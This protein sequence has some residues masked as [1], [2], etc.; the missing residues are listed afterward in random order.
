M[1]KKKNDDSKND[2]S[3]GFSP[4]KNLSYF[5]FVSLASGLK[6]MLKPFLREHEAYAFGMQ[7]FFYYQIRANFV[8][9]QTARMETLAI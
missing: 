6:K 2:T 7:S 9:C 1:G 5:F 8:Q 3:L 4:C